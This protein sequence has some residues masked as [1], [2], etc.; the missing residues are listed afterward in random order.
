MNGPSW[1]ER[2]H[3]EESLLVAYF[4][5]EFGLAENLP[6]YAGGLGILAGDHLRS[7]GDLGVPVVGVGH[8][9]RRGYFRQSI[10]DGRQ[11]ESYPELDPS[12]AGLSL[13][14][15]PDESPLLV[16]VE[17]AG[18]PVLAQI[19]RSE[20]RGSPVYL[21][22]SDVE[23]ND[24]TAR[25]VTDVLYGPDREHRIRQE[26]LLGVGGARALVALGL[27]PTVYHLNEG[28]AA[29]LALERVRAFVE[30]DG[31][32]FDE[33]L[34][35]VRQSTVFTTHTPVPAGNERFDVELAGRY[36]E[37]LARGC[38]TPVGDLLELGR[39]PGDDAFGL[40]PLALRTAA[41][42]NGVSELHG[43]VSRRMWHGLW[44][45]R[46]IEDVPIG[47]VT[48]AVHAPTWVSAEIQS[49]L[50]GAG[51][52]LD[53][54]SGEQDWE[55]AA[56]LDLAALWNAHRHGKARLLDTLAGRSRGRVGGDRLDP[57]ALT[58]AFARRVVSYKRA[59][60]LFTD[61]ER[62]LELF[63]NEERP[64]QLLY[65]GKAYPTDE[66]GK[67]ILAEVVRIARSRESCGRIVYLEDYDIELGR[68]LVQGADVW[69]NT[70]RRPEE[71]S[72]TS[73]MKAA[74]NGA[75]NLSVLDG[76][77]PE[78]YSPAVGWAISED[79]SEQ[80]DEA[81]ATELLRLLEEEVVPAF[82]DRGPDGL[83]LRWLE[84]MRASIATVGETF[85]GARMVAEYAERYYLPAHASGARGETPPR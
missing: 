82:Y 74:M 15:G 33:A 6:I 5:P 14:R 80:G 39:A 81:E 36:L 52:K 37:G 45:G 56:D 78:A 49:L 4:S 7:A 72:G 18:K 9:Y 42:A 46:R 54:G 3:G 28:H 62:A 31:L 27:E 61:V 69:L 32:G 48:N 76:W 51:V 17:L 66:E 70:P 30:D 34:E 53:G 12:G 11:H 79:I 67:A 63:A 8:L 25:A 41:Y 19:W 26:V 68:L 59:T 38:G 55:C 2:E 1:W 43:E 23:E 60:L 77:W 20:A 29:F 65:T 22:D 10:V 44:P 21:L 35:R 24:A 47:H 13:E 83:P 16:E 57:E 40:T 50:T 71:A 75:L 85:N 64:I 73:G 58:L 84:M